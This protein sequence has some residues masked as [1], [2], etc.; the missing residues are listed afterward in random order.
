MDRRLDKSTGRWVDVKFQ[1]KRLIQARE[2]HGYGF[3]EFADRL[4]I[5]PEELELMELGELEPPDNVLQKVCFLTGFLIA[6]FYKEP[7]PESEF[8]IPAKEALGM[9]EKETE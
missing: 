8:E 3:E 5:T 2:I 6:W 9:V 1:G 7:L 4:S